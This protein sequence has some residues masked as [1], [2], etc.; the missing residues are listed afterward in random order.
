M[1]SPTS[2]VTAV[3]QL[4][5]RWQIPLVTAR[6]ELR[7]VLFLA[8]SLLLQLNSQTTFR[9]A[10]AHKTDTEQQQA[11]SETTRSRSLFP[12]SDACCRIPASWQ[13]LLLKITRA[14]HATRG[15]M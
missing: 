9:S 7:K 12:G 5:L 11:D 3:F 4:N 6:S 13:Q 15:H 10:E 1:Y 8:L 14:V 2:V